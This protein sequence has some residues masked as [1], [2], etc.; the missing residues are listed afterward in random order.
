M[1][2]VLKKPIVRWILFFTLL[3]GV[4]V[5]TRLISIGAM[6]IFTDEAIYIRWAQIGANDPAWRLISLTDGKQPLF[7]WVIMACLRFIEDPLVAGRMA[8]VISGTLSLFAFP[9]LSYA[10]L[11]TIVPGAVASLLYVLSPTALLYDRMALYDGLVAALFIL[12]TALSILL[13]RKVRL[14]VALLLG[15]GLGFAMLNKTSG[16]L[17]LYLLP[18]TLILFDW[19]KK[20]RIR[21][22]LTWLGYVVVAGVVSQMMY[23]VLRLSPFL[24]I[25]AQKDALFVYPFKE[26]LQHPFT[27]LYG[28]LRGM[29]N[30][31][32]S[33]VS[34]PMIGA[35][36]YATCRHDGK[37]WR[38]VLLMLGYF[39]APF[40]ALAVFGKTL[41]PRYILFMT[42]P[43]VFLAAWGLWQWWK[44]NRTY[45][46]KLLVFIA[47]LPYIVASGWMLI[48]IRTAPLLKSDSSQY[49]NDWP[50]GWGVLEIA[51]LLS[52]QSKKEKVTV[53]TEGTF[54][55]MPYALEIYLSGN[56]NVEII[57]IWPF[58]KTIPDD[59]RIKATERPV[60]LVMYQSQTDPAWPVEK[61]LS[62]AQ[63]RNELIRMRL[64]KISAF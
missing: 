14:D 6:P 24:Y 58:P 19:S 41:Y 22:L 29:I 21:R 50:A 27:Y 56:K 23:A 49:V 2:T 52:E 46:G 47:V 43:I 61:V 40:L 38:E 64:Y 28:N 44:E 55:L 51:S 31:F 53:Y 63:G 11:G 48:D 30:W 15:I 57:G 4:Y 9:L 5:F 16:F 39:V 8:S 17:S 25:I 62:V 37:K 45:W 7:S 54:G 33:Y 3:I 32:I 18:M 34:L 26:W 10:L 36:V 12:N 42:M 20:D 35:A 13:A 60:Y 1:F 59:I